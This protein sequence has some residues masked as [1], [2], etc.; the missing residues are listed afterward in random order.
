M[1]D[2]K[3]G[4]CHRNPKRSEKILIKAPSPR[5]DDWP[6]PPSWIESVGSNRFVGPAIF[7][8]ALCLRLFQLA[9]QN[10]WYDEQLTVAVSQ[11]DGKD[12]FKALEIESNKPPLY[13]LLMHYWLKT[14]TSEFSV[15][16]PSALCGALTCLLAL[17]LGNELFGRNRGWLLGLGLSIAPFHVYYSQEARMYALLGL[18]GAGGMICTVI[19][20]KTQ[21]WRY[22]ALYSLCATLSCYTFTYGIFLLIFSSLFSLAFR[23][24]ISS[25]ALLVIFGANI[26]SGLLFCLWLPRLFE[27]MQSGTGLQML[28]RAPVIVALAYT[29]LTLGLGTTFGPTTEQLRVLGARVFAENP[30]G[31][32]LL[33]GGLLL[34]IVVTVAG[35][36]FW[37]RRRRNVFFFA[38]LGLI[39]FCGCP[40]LLNLL[41]PGI[42]YN[43]RYAVLAL[44]PF[45]TAVS[46]LLLSALEKKGWRTGCVALFLGCV[47]ISLF[48]HFF[49]AKYARDDVRSAVRFVERLTPTPRLLIVC[50]DFMERSVRY[51]YRGAAR[52]VPLETRSRS[53][54][55]AFEPLNRELDEAKTFGL[56]Y[57]RPDHGDPQG[58]LPDWLAQHYRLKRQQSWTGVVFY[59]FENGEEGAKP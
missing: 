29:Y 11:A 34:T 39:V 47:G 16:L 12:F 40:A 57:T 44:F 31:G 32:M 18:I 6:E 33:A 49:V 51:Y 46:G 4:F 15:R 13:F 35:L 10:L 50:A 2:G 3:D 1:R 22:A 21:Q 27:S 28:S 56:L 55:Q 54:E 43:A 7:V 24:R 30:S 58:I 37:W 48:N 26:L 8:L 53:V 14:G 52:V 20:C 45:L 23:P 17:F 59:L 42:P 25:R 38:S 41:K 5:L 36:S 9:D 19:F